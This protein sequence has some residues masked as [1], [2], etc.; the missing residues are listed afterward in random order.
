MILRR[1]LHNGERGAAKPRPAP[2]ARKAE[3]GVA[4]VIAVVSIAILTAVAVDFRYNAHVDLR[5]AANQRDDAQAYFLAKSSIGLSRLVLSFQRHL[6]N[7]PVPFS[8]PGVPNRSTGFR[9]QLHQLARVDCHMLRSMVTSGN[10]AEPRRE[11]SGRADSEVEAVRAPPRRSFGGFTGCFDSNMQAEETKINL[12]ALNAVT[13]PTALPALRILTDKRFEFLF[14]TEDRN[15]VRVTPQELLI[16]LQDWADPDEV[17]SSLNLTG[18][19]KTFVAGFTDEN[20]DYMRYEPRYETKNA[21]FDSLDEL[22]L[23]HGVNDRI[24]AALRERLTVYPSINGAANINAD[25]PVLLLFAIQNVVDLPKATHTKFKDP[26][27]WVEVVNAVRKAR[28]ISVLGLSMKDFRAIL[29][30]LGI[31]V[32]SDYARFVS[33]RNTTFTIHGTGTGG[34]V[35]RKLTAV[36]RM[37]TGGLGR[38]VYWREE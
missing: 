35:T 13:A 29:Q 17:Q 8:L 38:L 18:A 20:G 24:M 7:I 22:Y 31:P 5:T 21:Y 9:I 34:N 26:L 30:G 14:E 25:D 1:V 19:G 16:H 3:R 37:D 33:D 6:D 36:V 28:V 12:N 4:M 32:K 27:F 2:S 15:R 11:E 10:E 23:V